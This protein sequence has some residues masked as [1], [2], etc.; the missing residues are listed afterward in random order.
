MEYLAIRSTPGIAAAQDGG[1]CHHHFDVACPKCRRKYGFWGP[2][3]EFEEQLRLDREN[4]LTEFLAN[5]CPFHK[6]S[7]A[8][9]GLDELTSESP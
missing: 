1:S 6:D 5:V 3:P 4:W 9:P 7:F 8:L 2:L